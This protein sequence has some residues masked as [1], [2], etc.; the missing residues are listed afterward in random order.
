VLWGAPAGASKVYRIEVEGPIFEPVVRYLQIA[1]EQAER[2]HADALLFE[3]DTPGGSL[4]ATKEIVETILGAPVPVIVYVAP[5]GASASSAG[6]FV[7]LAAHV[8]AMAPGTTIGAAHPVMM[9]PTEKRDEVMEKKVENYAVSLAEALATQRGRNVNWAAEAVRE[10]ASITA[11]KALEKQV[12]DLLALSREELL[13]AVDGRTVKLRGRD[14]QL[15]T[16]EPE[17]RDVDMTLEQR[18]YFFLSQPTVIFLLMVAG[19]AALYVE[20]THPGVIAPG[21]IGAICILLAAIGFSIVPINLTGAA[22]LLLGV[23]MLIAEVFVPSF[24]ALGV[25]G[26]LCFMAGAVLLFQTV[27]APGLTINPGVIAAT[28]VGFASL[29]LGIGTLVTR[30]QRRP[31]ATGREAMIGERGSVL[32]RLAPR[33]KV[34]VMGEVWDAVLEGEGSAE[35]GAEVE[36]VR[37]EG[38]KLIVKPVRR[39]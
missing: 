39:S 13:K 12:I 20:F 7:T 36:I 33:G 35:E 21:V 34:R 15:Q 1:L 11:E 10:S 17:F 31:V 19:A 9:I 32:R 24:G 26:F 8:A 38:L 5:S 4:D 2:E 3:L 27:E 29:L 25:G 18:F 37:L 22:L 28:S 30:A 16:A 14:V 23:A 6:T